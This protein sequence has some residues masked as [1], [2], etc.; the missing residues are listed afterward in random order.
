MIFHHRFSSNGHISL[1]IS[2]NYH[3]REMKKIK[4]TQCV[5]EKK[6]A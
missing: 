4:E 2:G 5:Q 6:S 3:G 1:E